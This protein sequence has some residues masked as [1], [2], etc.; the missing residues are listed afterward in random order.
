MYV[1][2]SN[3][4]H[5]TLSFENE[6]DQYFFDAGVKQCYRQETK[7]IARMLFN[8]WMINHCFKVIY[9]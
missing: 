9:F 4:I 5:F 6:S 7:I 2:L 8:N 1:C 3:E